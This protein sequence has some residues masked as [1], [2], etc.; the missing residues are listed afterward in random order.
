[1]YNPTM[2][3]LAI[4]ELLQSHEQLSA[5]ELAQRLA[6]KERS[7]RRYIT[8]LRDMGIPIESE[9]GRYG[10]YS[11]LPGYRLP[12]MMF[13]HDEIVQ[14]M[15]GLMLMREIGTV[16]VLAVDSAVS[17]IERVLP[18]ELGR[19]TQALRQALSLDMMAFPTQA[20]SSQR[21][22]TVSLAA[23]DKR[24]LQI[25]YLS[26]KGEH[27]QRIISPYG[28]VLHGNNWYV[29]AYCHLRDDLRIFRL[30]RFQSVAESDL[31]FNDMDLKPQSYVLKTLAHTPGLHEFKVILHASLETASEIIPQSIAILE[32]HAG[33]TLLRCYADDPYW[34]ARYLARL[35]LPFSVL[36]TDELR[37]AIKSIAGQML[38]GIEKS[39]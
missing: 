36:E 10:G 22:L 19:H 15:T 29:P 3:L 8:M 13:N 16:S 5:H 27:S 14:V 6:V 26:A 37:V 31:A 34:L 35:E 11:L 4:L 9:R 39:E 7:I 33:E 18:E 20:V 21:I 1:M 30:D 24:C 25:A 17:K 12:P 38:A 23:V 32:E 2:R 28:I